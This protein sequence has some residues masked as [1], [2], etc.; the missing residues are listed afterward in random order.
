M[1]GR[2]GRSG[3]S[4]DRARAAVSTP[5]PAM[6]WRPDQ[7]GQFLDHAHDDRL[8]A[9]GHAEVGRGERTI[10]LDAGTVDSLRAH[11]Q[12]QRK[13]RMAAGTVWVNSG[14]VFTARGPVRSLRPRC[15]R[16]RRSRWV[17]V[18]T[19]SS[20]PAA[21][22]CDDAGPAVDLGCAGRWRSRRTACQDARAVADAGI[23]V[24]WARAV[25]R[26]VP[27]GRASG[28]TNGSRSAAAWRFSTTPTRGWRTGRRASSSTAPAV[29]CSS[30]S[31]PGRRAS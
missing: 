16:Q 13:D 20:Y 22:P 27:P 8:Y 11:R 23:G 15:G 9:G 30:S 25:G 18:R 14:K 21:A 24:L 12:Q 7:L 4:V 19:P 29:T 26:P 2:G 17:R 3:T 6:V 5:S 31:A 10:A 1:A 28:T